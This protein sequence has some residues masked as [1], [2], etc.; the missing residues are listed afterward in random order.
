MGGQ[1]SGTHPA[2]F[3]TTLTEDGGRLEKILFA[4]VSAR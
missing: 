2:R 3:G 1:I 4:P